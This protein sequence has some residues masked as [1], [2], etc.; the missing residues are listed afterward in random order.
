VVETGKRNLR[1]SNFVKMGATPEEHGATRPQQKA[2]ALAANGRELTR[3]GR[4]GVSRAACASPAALLLLAIDG[5]ERHGR[6]AAS[7]VSS[8]FQRF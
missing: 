1:E 5:H 2:K 7:T 4:R 8:L 6:L 3:M